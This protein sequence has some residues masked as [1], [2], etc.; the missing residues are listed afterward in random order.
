[1]KRSCRSKI[2]TYRLGQEN[3]TK[4][5]VIAVFEGNKAK[6]GVNARGN[7]QDLARAYIAAGRTIESRE[8]LQ[9]I[10]ESPWARP[11]SWKE[12]EEFF[13][14]YQ[15]ELIKAQEELEKLLTCS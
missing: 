1:M 11:L 15:Q 6:H 8:Q 7:L 2:L 13:T 5:Y 10:T 9:P 4:R 12:I 14:F 3:L